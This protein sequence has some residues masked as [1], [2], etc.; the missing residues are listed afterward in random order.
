MKLIHYT[1]P[2]LGSWSPFHRLSSFQDLLAS[3]GELAGGSAK[4]WTPALDVFETDEAI[5]VRVELG[6]MKKE[7][8]DISLEDDTLAIS[9]CREWPNEDRRVE[10]FRSELFR[11]TFHRE[12]VMPCPVKTDAVKAAYTDGILVIEVPKAE[13]AKPRKIAVG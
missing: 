7:D 4:P 11:G 2:T 5:T 6:G 12:V 3:S 8:F 1:T 10:S 13:E 9:G